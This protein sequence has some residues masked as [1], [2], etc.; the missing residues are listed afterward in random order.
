MVKVWITGVAGSLGSFLANELVKRGYRVAGNDIKSPED[1]YLG[2]LSREVEYLW[3]ANEDL[4]PRDLDDYQIIVN[5]AA[6][7]DRP[8]GIS[9]PSHVFLN[10]TLS[11]LKLLEVLRETKPEKIVHAGSGTVYIGS[12]LPATESTRPTPRNPYSVSKLAQDEI[13]LSYYRAYGLPCV[14]V[15]SGMVYG[16]GRLAIAPHRFMIQALRGEPITVFGGRQTRTPTHLSDVLKYWLKI[17]EAPAE[18]VVGRV[19]HTVYPTSPDQ[20]GEY[21]I[22]EMALM[23]KEITESKS[24]ILILPYEPGEHEN[25]KPLREWIISTTAHQLGVKPEIDLK[26]G[27]EL[28]LDWIKEVVRR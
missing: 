21:T 2:G 20:K 4:T 23:V 3:K 28:T 5:C 24:E 9:S 6:S 18:K 7:P 8:M 19:I 11:I 25:N 10:N 17:I 13:A 15:R 16:G 26:R 14:I 22:L 12:D 1:A 27:L